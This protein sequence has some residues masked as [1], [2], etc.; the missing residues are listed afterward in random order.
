[1]NQKESRTENPDLCILF[2]AVVSDID[3]NMS[4]VSVLPEYLH[5]NEIKVINAIIV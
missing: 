5:E 3:C 4:A 1:M 2:I